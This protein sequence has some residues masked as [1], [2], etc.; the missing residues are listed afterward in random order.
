MPGKGLELRQCLKPVLLGKCIKSPSVGECNDY[1]AIL[2]L[3]SKIPIQLTST[4]RQLNT[5]PHW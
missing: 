2:D 1:E 3:C 4:E 5:L